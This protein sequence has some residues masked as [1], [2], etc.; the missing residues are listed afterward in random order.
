[1]LIVPL[2]RRWRRRPWWN[3]VRFTLLA[4]RAPIIWRLVDGDRPSLVWLALSG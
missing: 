1:M 3:A 2:V 4:Q